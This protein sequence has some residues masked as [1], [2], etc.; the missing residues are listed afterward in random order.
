MTGNEI[1]SLIY[2]WADQKNIHPDD[3]HSMFVPELLE[4]MENEV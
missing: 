2:E 1:A 4:M 3:F